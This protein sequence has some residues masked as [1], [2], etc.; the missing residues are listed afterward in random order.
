MSNDINSVVVTGRLTRDAELRYSNSGTAICK[1]SIASNYSMKRGD[2]WNEE[3]SYFDATMFS[4]RAEAL[5]KYLTKGTPVALHGE[6]RQNR[7]EQDGQ[8]RSRVE[9]VIRDV[10]LPGGH[11]DGASQ[12]PPPPPAEGFE[13]DVPF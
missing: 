2:S 8:Q 4:R 12:A 3:V 11:K 5:H 9:I 7:W 1:M 10:K 6:L 13:D